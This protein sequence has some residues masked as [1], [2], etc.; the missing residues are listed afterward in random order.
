VKDACTIWR[1][2]IW[3]A[4]DG[5]VAENQCLALGGHLR[6]CAGCRQVFVQS[7]AAHRALHEGG[8]PLASLASFLEGAQPAKTAAPE[9]PARHVPSRTQ[10]ERARRTRIWRWLIPTLSVGGMALAA[11]AYRQA[12]RQHHDRPEAGLEATS[13]GRVRRAALGSRLDLAAAG[14]TDAGHF[15]GGPN[16]MFETGQSFVREGGTAE[17]GVHLVNPSTEPVRV[18]VKVVSGTATGQGCPP[19]GAAALH[20][21]GRDFEI[22]NEVLTFAP[23]QSR[24]TIRVASFD[25]DRP[26]ADETVDL[27][28]A[29]EDG[30]QEAPGTRHRLVITD[31]DRTA[32]V[33]VVTD[34]GAAGDGVTDDTVA[35]QGALD[36]AARAGRGVVVLP[37]REYLASRLLLPP[38]ITVEGYGAVLKRHPPR[39]G[40]GSFIKAR[41]SGDTDAPPTVVRGLTLDG[42]APPAGP[43]GQ[44]R[45]GKQALLYLGADAKRPGR[46]PVILEDF[47]VRN[48]VSRGIEIGTNVLTT[49]LRS[50]A[51]DVS[52]G[53]V[54]LVGGNSRLE[55][56]NLS[57]RQSVRG[58]PTGLFIN[59]REPGYRQGL[60]ASIAIDGVRIVGG[61]FSVTA[62]SGSE[63]VVNDVDVDGPLFLRLPDSTATITRSRF[64]GGA[65]G[66]ERNRIICPGRLTIEASELAAVR[67]ARAKAGSRFA[68][69][70]VQ[71][72]YGPCGKAGR[73]QSLLL[74]DVT[75]RAEGAF[76]PDDVVNVVRAQD[77]PQASGNVLTIE[78]GHVFPEFPDG[79]WSQRA[80]RWIFRD[81]FTDAPLIFTVHRRASELAGPNRRFSADLPQ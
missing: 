74:K 53:A 56:C 4:L 41:Y 50:D 21:S 70:L 17:I 1:E 71:W 28:L 12:G 69:A 16:V 15:A 30:S 20:G 25:D 46:M 38:G 23:G 7:V 27:V 64:R 55:V 54:H 60:R 6:S 81:V 67:S 57:A 73:Q 58:R 75:F 42:Q 61:A 40:Y 48:G 59:L 26:E 34:F 32:L 65:F 3:D 31:D 19:G 13:P 78:G 47:R 68:A 10:G 14:A 9:A 44:V 35:I 45:M 39:A 62:P 49:L 76:E 22:P 36:A 63:I 72:A 33:E 29:L 80:S 79:F 37:P 11:L 66:L 8:V 51:E 5:D 2:A 77:D 52:N 43:P 24:Q 18:T